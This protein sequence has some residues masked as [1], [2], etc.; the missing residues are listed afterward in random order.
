LATSTA[1]ELTAF[2]A[3]AEAGWPQGDEGWLTA[4]S[5]WCG[6]VD[7]SAREAG[8]SQSVPTAFSCH[9]GAS[10]PGLSSC[11]DSAGSASPGRLDTSKPGTF[12]Y[13]VT[14]TSKDGQ[15]GRAR[16]S[17]TV[18]AGPPQPPPSGPPGSPSGG[19]PPTPET[20][21]SVGPPRVN[22]LTVRIPVSCQ[23]AATPQCTIS[24]RLYV[25]EVFRG[26]PLTAVKPL[27][28]RPPKRAGHPCKHTAK[29]K[30]H[31][32]ITYQR[33]LIGATTVRLAPGHQEVA[34]LT[35]NRSGRRLLAVRRPLRARLVV[36]AGGK[37]QASHVVRFTAA[38]S[39]Q[40][41]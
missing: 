8:G 37:R 24:L 38:H 3:S 9:E 39:H 20:L 31:P 17:Y 4:S 23:T 14:A 35:L 29:C 19:N 16:I 26:H 12:T 36:F 5:G 33:V 30:H 40:K 25:Q 6:A 18:S 22:Q 34:P 32:K 41:H 2:A 15:T 11:V 28:S 1:L 13:V 27:A 21:V 7:G 10:G